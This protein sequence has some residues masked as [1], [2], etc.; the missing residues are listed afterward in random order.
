MAD[1]FVDLLV[2]KTRAWKH[3]N[4]IDPS[5]DMGTVI[6]EAAAKLFESRVNEAVAQGAKLLVG[7]KRE[8][9]SIRPR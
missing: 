4:P 1:R 5:I 2:D 8:A 3:G 6:D 7:N 9:R